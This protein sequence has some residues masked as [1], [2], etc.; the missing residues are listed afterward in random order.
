MMLDN[1]C[2][3]TITAVAYLIAVQYIHVLPVRV[4]V[5]VGVLAF[6]PPHAHRLSSPF[7][8]PRERSP[9]LVPAHEAPDADINTAHVRVSHDEVVHVQHASHASDNKRRD[10]L[11][12]AAAAAAT[13]FIPV[14]TS[15]CKPALA[16]AAAAAA[17][18]Q[19][20]SAICHPEV[21]VFRKGNRWLRIIGT[22][23]I[24]SVSAD[25]AR[26]LVRETSPD[27]V[28][29]ELDLKR[30]GRAFRSGRPTPGLNIGY[31][32]DKGNLKIGTVAAE[33]PRRGGP[34]SAMIYKI[35]SKGADV[36]GNPIQSMYKKLE[37]DGFIPGAE[38]IN[39]VEEGLDQGATIVLGDRDMDVTL[40]RIAQALASTDPKKLQE[41]DKKLTETMKNEIPEVEEWQRTGKVALEPDEFK[42]FIETLKSRDTT[43]R[44]MAIF[45]Q[46]VPQIHDAL[47]A[48]RDVYM[49]NNI[50][51][52]SQFQSMVAVMGLGHLD[53]VRTR[54]GQLGWTATVKPCR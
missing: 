49:A 51:R 9:F 32:D 18:A 27:A 53:G 42:D 13:A 40:R 1:K 50:D 29:V 7:S 45:Q 26:Q 3:L 12:A 37:S 11:Q 35:L 20:Q 23:H 6:E 19:S 36:I 52:L 10:I 43:D 46:E 25:L 31:Q 8:A 41:V 33:G 2:A 30:I 48:E 21:L 4:G 38:F 22:A 28:F 44:L 14:D 34:V 39:A 15:T 47:V 5:H 16:A 17:A 24:S 54:L